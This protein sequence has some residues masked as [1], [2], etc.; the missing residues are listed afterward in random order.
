MGSISGDI[1]NSVSSWKKLFS[2]HQGDP[3][4]PQ[5]WQKVASVGLK[6]LSQGLFDKANQQPQR[7][8]PVSINVP[9]APP[10]NQQPMSVYP[11]KGG[12]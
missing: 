10:V 8:N 9:D 12:Y 11:W 6:A 1:A 5:D 4:Q 7:R 2:D 3:N